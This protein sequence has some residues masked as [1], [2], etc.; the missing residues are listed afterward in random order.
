MLEGKEG[1][2]SGNT[3][4]NKTTQMNHGEVDTSHHQNPS[5]TM[6]MGH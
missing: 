3:T 4:P 5:G 1:Q 6:Q 2:N